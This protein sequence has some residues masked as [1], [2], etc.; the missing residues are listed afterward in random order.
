[1]DLESR[2]TL[3]EQK[4]DMIVE[5]LKQ[6]GKKMRDHIDFIEGVYETIKNPFYYILDKINVYKKIDKLENKDV[7]LQR[8][9]CREKLIDA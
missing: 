8:L 4:M 1:M 5:L 3:L 9:N 7:S 6:D 2:L